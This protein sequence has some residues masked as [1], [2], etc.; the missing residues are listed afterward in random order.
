MT[1]MRVKDLLLLGIGKWDVAKTWDIFPMAVDTKILHIAILPTDLIWGLEKS[2]KFNVKSTY[3]IIAEDQ[4]KVEGESSTNL[5]YFWNGLS[6]DM[7]PSK[8]KIRAWRACHNCLS[9]MRELLLKKIT[10]D[11]LHAKF[12][13]KY[14]RMC[15]MS[16]LGAKIYSPTSKTSF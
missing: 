6:K 14:L 12:A 4:A 3:K 7:V 13:R 9:T 15:I 16:S 2:E 8:V 11:D 1:D 10:I 5:S